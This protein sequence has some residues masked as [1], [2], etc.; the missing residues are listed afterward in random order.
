M[1]ALLVGGVGIGNAIRAHIQGRLT[2]IATLKCLG[3]S[4]AL[5]IQTI[6]PQIGI[7]AMLGIAIGCA[8]GAVAP[9]LVADL[10]SARL[11][12]TVEIGFHPLPLALAAVF[13]FLVS[14]TFAVVPLDQSRKIKPAALFRSG[15][16]LFQ[17]LPSFRAMLWIVAAIAILLLAALYTARD[18]WLASGFL[19]GAGATLLVFRLTAGAVT[20]LAAKGS[21]YGPAIMRM[22]LANLHRPGASTASIVMSL[23]LGLTILVAVTL[24]E[25]N[26][27][28]QINAVLAGEAPGFYF[29]DV[30]QDQVAPFTKLLDT[31]DVVNHFESVPMLRG[32]IE[33]LNH[34]PVAEIDVPSQYSWVVRGDRG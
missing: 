6:A 12:I 34:V 2:A 24:T 10:L 14:V 22:G 1:T 33:S 17:S 9:I 21:G 8:V 32:T 30:Q 3:A 15:T 26:M 20:W 19:L 4:S 7:L 5:V 16:A 18:Q 11:P 31:H 13:G 29:I 27:N 25:S 23:G 28:R